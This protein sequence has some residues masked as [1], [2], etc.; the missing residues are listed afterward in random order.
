MRLRAAM[1]G[2]CAPTYIPNSSSGLCTFVAYAAAGGRCFPPFLCPL[3]VVWLSSFVAMCRC[4]P[5]LVLGGCCRT[6]RRNSV[7]RVNTI[8]GLAGALCG[9]QHADLKACG[10]VRQHC[11]TL[12]L[13][14]QE[15]Q[16]ATWSCRHHYFDQA[17]RSNATPGCF[18]F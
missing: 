16:A 5:T 7:P 11:H 8:Q 9:R 10:T 18:G 2:S 14:S 4:A 1:Y 3:F 6:C 17:P 12:V 13:S 15:K